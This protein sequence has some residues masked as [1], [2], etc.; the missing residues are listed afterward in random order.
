VLTLLYQRSTLRTPYRLR[1]V[2]DKL[3]PTLLVQRVSTLLEGVDRKVV[4]ALQADT[5]RTLGAL[6]ELTLQDV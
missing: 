6:I 3:G 2:L 4:H 5:A 1:C